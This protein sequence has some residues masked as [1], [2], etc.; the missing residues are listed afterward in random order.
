M[1]LTLTKVKTYN[2][3]LTFKARD[4]LWESKLAKA[5]EVLASHARLGLV[6][7]HGGGLVVR[8]VRLRATETM[9]DRR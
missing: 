8:G 7:P 2:E 1:G 6:Q 9:G 4:V 5:R 3:R